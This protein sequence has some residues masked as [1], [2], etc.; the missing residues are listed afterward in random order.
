M[1]VWD[2]LV[3]I[4]SPA[5]MADI[6]TS[7]GCIAMHGI[8]GSLPPVW[9]SL[10]QLRVQAVACTGLTGQLPKEYGA[11]KILGVLEVSGAQLT[12]NL[13][14]EWA[15]ATAMKAVLADALATAQQASQQAA[16][17]EASQ[18]QALPRAT[19]AAVHAPTGVTAMVINAE[20][21]MLGARQR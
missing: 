5:H 20:P 18:A 13:P 7:C 6:S 21:V 12:G 2:N 3:T 8:S 17:E 4:A 1:L 19:S 16:M 11:P 9:A 10:Q 14:M 15:D